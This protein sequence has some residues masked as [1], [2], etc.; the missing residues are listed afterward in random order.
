M[1]QTSST[2]PIGEILLLLF[3]SIPFL[4]ILYDTGTILYS[5]LLIAVLVGI[6]WD[7]FWGQDGD[8]G[9]GNLNKT[10]RIVVLLGAF[11]ILASVIFFV[12]PPISLYANV[13]LGLAVGIIVVRISRLVI[14]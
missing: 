3:V 7:V 12:N 9:F 1:P 5:V 14:K 11:G 8:L 10:M 13:S 2:R 6:G 4:V